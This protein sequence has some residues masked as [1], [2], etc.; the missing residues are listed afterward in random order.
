MPQ[1]AYLRL[2]IR[3]TPKELGPISDWQ[4]MTV[5]LADKIAGEIDSLADLFFIRLIENLPRLVN[6]P[7]VV[8]SVPEILFP[9]NERLSIDSE[10]R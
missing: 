6:S 9:L 1:L 7:R 5:V 8:G 10:R 3:P 4:S 2:P